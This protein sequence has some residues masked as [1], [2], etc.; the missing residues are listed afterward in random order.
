M[1]GSSVVC[2]VDQP[3]ACFREEWHGQAEA[4]RLRMVRSSGGQDDRSPVTRDRHAGSV[5][6]GG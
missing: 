5:G 6:A 1:A 2:S 4:V 3:G